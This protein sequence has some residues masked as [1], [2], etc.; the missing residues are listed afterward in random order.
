MELLLETTIIEMKGI[1]YIA[2][3]LEAMY[4]ILSGYFH[5]QNLVYS[6]GQINI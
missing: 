4:S 6:T 5:T 1:V 2:L 3:D